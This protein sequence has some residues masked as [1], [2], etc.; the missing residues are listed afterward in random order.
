MKNPMLVKAKIE[1]ALRG[2]SRDNPAEP[3]RVSYPDW[4]RAHVRYIVLGFRIFRS[5]E[6]L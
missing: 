1:R 6:K 4:D 2:G 5:K 3:M